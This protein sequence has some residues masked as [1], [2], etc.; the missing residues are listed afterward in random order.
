MSK[1]KCLISTTENAGRRVAGL[2]VLGSMVMLSGCAA[3]TMALVNL[4][5]NP[6][7]KKIE[8]A[9]SAG[10]A[11]QMNV[12][13]SDLMSDADFNA[14]GLQTGFS[15]LKTSNYLVMDAARVTDK[16]KTLI[17]VR[18]IE[19]PADNLY[20]FEYA[21]PAEKNTYVKKA[22]S[23]SSE[24]ELSRA[25]GITDFY[26]I[27]SLTDYLL[28][29]KDDGCSTV[30]ENDYKG[31]ILLEECS[32]SDFSYKVTDFANF[33]NGFVFPKTFSY[34][35]YNGRTYNYEVT[36]VKNINSKKINTSNRL[37]KN[38][39][40]EFK[41]RIRNGEVERADG[42]DLSDIWMELQHTPD[43]ESVKGKTGSAGTK[44]K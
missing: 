12:V 17:R 35:G 36:S 7:M 32:G 22:Y 43:I 20:A 42:S 38:V 8:N 39:A 6:D 13:N 28:S 1:G 37:M 30:R 29:V 18:V 4:T 25:L 23:F 3:A 15:I 10:Y 5:G 40:V 11:L 44:K 14:P 27:K 26:S 41:E 21:V 24:K 31:L 2:T 16:K 34:R 33:D 19:M 9:R